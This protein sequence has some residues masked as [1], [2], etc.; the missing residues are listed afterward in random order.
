MSGGERKLYVYGAGGHAR[1]VAETATRAGFKVLGVVDDRAEKAG[2]NVCG[3]RVCSWSIE[4]LAR[5]T[6]DADAEVIVGIGDNWARKR[7]FERLFR[8]GIRIATVLS[9][10][11]CVFDSVGVGVGSFVAAG[12]VVT[13]GTRIGRNV[14]VNTGASLDH[15]GVISDHVH[16]SLGAHVGGAVVVGEGTHVGIGCSVRN[17]VSLGSWS[18]IGAGA[19]VV[20]D[21]ESGVV[22]YGVPARAV[23]PTRTSEPGYSILEHGTGETPA[24]RS[25]I[26]GDSHCELLSPHD[27]LWREL[28]ARG[29]GDPYQLPEYVAVEARRAGGEPRGLAVVEGQNF[30]LMPLVFRQVAPELTDG[31]TIL[32]AASPYGTPGFLVGGS[33]AGRTEWTMKAMS[34]GIQALAKAGVCSLFVRLHPLMQEPVEALS[35]FGEIVDQGPT[36]WMDLRWDDARYLDNL[37]ENHRRVLKR[38]ERI[39]AKVSLDSGFEKLSEFRAI[40]CETME[41]VKAADWYFF[42]EDYFRDFAR[43]VGAAV[44]LITVEVDGRM[45]SGALFLHSNATV[46]YFLGATGRDARGMAPSRLVFDFARRYFREH[47]ANVLHLGGGLAGATDSLFNFK[48][49]FSPLRG[50]FATWRV[51]TD[52]ARYSELCDAWV[53]RG[54]TGSL[55][56]SGYFPPYRQQLHAPARPVSEASR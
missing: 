14:I 2:A 46:Q 25:V 24:A 45:V 20:A 22:A 1:V 26:S 42:S 35:G 3:F 43:T 41:D 34:V 10:S 8:A 52:R 21:I 32:D 23:R 7:V 19:V 5:E 29:G 9:P 49:G 47:G 6:R 11:A 40:Y 36:V 33:P 13:T 48:A 30:L 53:E 31:R 28:H 39:G 51:V 37:R 54:G 38:L 4:E 15:D 56:S 17:N 50:R 18:L 44:C 27:S 55:E 16:I 12:A